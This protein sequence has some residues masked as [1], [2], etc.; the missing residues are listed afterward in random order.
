M[1]NLAQVIK[2][3]READALSAHINL[4]AIAARGS[5]SRAQSNALPRKAIGAITAPTPSAT[6]EIVTFAPMTSPKAIP[7]E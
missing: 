1:L 6:R 5:P 2:P 4:Y 7:G 3:W